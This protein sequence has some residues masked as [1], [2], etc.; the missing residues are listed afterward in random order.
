MAQWSKAFLF[1]GFVIIAPA[2]IFM[3]FGSGKIQ[4]WNDPQQEEKDQCEPERSVNV[5]TIEIPSD[6]VTRL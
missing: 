2:I 6:L 3:I 4:T 1:G 5:A